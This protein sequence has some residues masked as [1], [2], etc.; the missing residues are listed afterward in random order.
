VRQALICLDCGATAASPR[1]RFCGHCGQILG[2]FEATEAE[3]P[4]AVEVAPQKDVAS[5]AAVSSR[6]GLWFSAGLVAALGLWL[7]VGLATG[8]GEV[9]PWP[10]ELEVGDAAEIV[11]EIEETGEPL[12]LPSVRD[13]RI[14]VVVFDPVDPVNQTLYLEHHPVVGDGGEA[15]GLMVLYLTDGRG[16]P[17]PWCASS[18]WFED[19]RHGTKYDWLGE[20]MDGP[21]PRG[22]DRFPSRVTSGGRLVVDL[23]W[24]IPGPARHA[25]FD[26]MRVWIDEESGAQVW[27]RPGTE[28]I[29]GPG[30]LG[31]HCND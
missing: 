29:P 20:W 23:G 25:R 6:P 13:A 31:P 5:P 27:N 10:G 4:T 24:L 2:S 11:E 21:G 7:L 15:V 1:A 9:D 22:L 19:G 26:G 3:A 28:G 12:L 30:P 8:R 14:A 17:T 16:N 18:G